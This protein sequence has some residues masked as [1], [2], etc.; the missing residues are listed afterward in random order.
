MVIE[1]GDVHWVD[2]GPATDGDHRPAKRRPVLVVQSDAYNA[3][4][5]ATVIVAVLTS[6]VDA[7]DLPGNTL[8]R[9]DATGLPRDSVV[10]VTSLAT[11]NRYD[12]ELPPVGRVPGDLMRTV[13]AGIAQ[14]LG[15]T[16][17]R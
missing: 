8:L 7:A 14:V 1:R 15:L 16:L 2:L 11:L 3:S 5:L 12:L 6:R 13:D 17:M 10:N 4:R 9:A